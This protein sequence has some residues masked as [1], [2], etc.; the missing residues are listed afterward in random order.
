MI[1]KDLQ[2]NISL[3]SQDGDFEFQIITRADLEEARQLHN[4]PLILNQLTDCRQI[5]KSQ[6]RLWFRNLQRSQT[7]TR[8]VIRLKADGS[9]VG[10]FRLD[11][12]DQGNATVCLGLDVHPRFQNQGN[13]KKIYREVIEML[14]SKLNFHR[15]YLETLESNGVGRKLYE[16]LGMKLE[17]MQ[18]E[19]IERHGIRVS[20]LNYGLLQNEWK[21]R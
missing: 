19:A 18:R 10:V 8:V 14:F 9:L 4:D 1:S 20:L 2:Q 17:G 3:L 6:Q 7:S 16:S 12:I 5:T 11:R 13:G 21:P 15:V